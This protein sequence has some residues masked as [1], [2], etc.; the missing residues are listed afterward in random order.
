MSTYSLLF[1][2]GRFF[3]AFDPFLVLFLVFPLLFIFTYCVFA[4]I[5]PS[6]QL[7]RTP[8][9]RAWYSPLFSWYSPQGILLYS[10]L[11]YLL[12]TNTHTPTK[13]AGFL[14]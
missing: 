14:V 1:Y 3:G 5:T 12:L 13:R 7:S 8:I 11:N 4:C 9:K 6:R 10:L 2:F